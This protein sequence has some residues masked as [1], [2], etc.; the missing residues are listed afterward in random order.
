MDLDGETR[1]KIEIA[2]RILSRHYFPVDVASEEI[3]LLIAEADEF[4]STLPLEEFAAVFIS[5]WRIRESLSTSSDIS[6]R[7]A[8]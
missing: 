6:R 7:F 8:S 4:D 3:E 5:R 1:K 2:L